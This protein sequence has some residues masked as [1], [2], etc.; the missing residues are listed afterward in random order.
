M[1]TIVATVLGVTVECVADSKGLFRL[2][3]LYTAITGLGNNAATSPKHWK[4]LPRFNELVNIIKAQRSDNPTFESKRGN[5]GGLFV[6][7]LMLHEYFRYLDP[8]Y[9]HAMLDSFSQAA[10]GDGEGAVDAAHAVVRVKSK[11][12]RN[13]F[14]S[15]IGRYGARNGDYAWATNLGY[16]ATLGRD[17]TQERIARGLS[18]NANLREHLSTKELNESMAYE[19]LAS[20]GLESAGRSGSFRSRYLQVSNLISD[21]MDQLK[22]PN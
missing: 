3:P 11:A 14:A 4:E 10:A 6:C 5:N 21:V 7:E 2:L 13:D 15:V 19:I 17:A 22:N 8:A 9:H 20:R 12:V 1:T 16:R 18:P